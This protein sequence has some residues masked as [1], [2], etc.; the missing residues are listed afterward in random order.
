MIVSS[1]IEDFTRFKRFEEAT[2]PTLPKGR[3]FP[4]LAYSGDITLNHKKI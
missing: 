2:Y 3:I 1:T 4:G